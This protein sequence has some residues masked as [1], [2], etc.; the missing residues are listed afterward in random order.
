MIPEVLIARF[1]ATATPPHDAMSI[2]RLALFDWAVCAIA[3]RDEPIARILRDLAEAE[4]AVGDRLPPARAALING[5]TSHALDY[6]DTHFAHIGHTSVAVMPAVLAL[7][8]GRTL[9]EVLQA[10]LIGSEV[11]VRVGLWLGRDHYQIGFHQTAT[12]GAFGAAMAASRLLG[13]TQ[14][15]MIAALGLVST[16]AAGLKSQ[17]GTMGKPLNAGLA[18]E[19]GVLAAQWAAGGMTS[20]DA[21]LGGALGFGATHHGA[22]DMA[23]F[24]RMGDDWLM[25]DVSHK[26]HACCHGLHATLEALK[27]LNGEVAELT[28]TTHPRWM[29]VCNILT[30]RSGLECK[31]SYRMVTAMHLSGISTAAIDSYSDQ[32][33]TDPA[34]ADIR[35]RVHVH[36][37]AALTEMQAQIDVTYDD[38]RKA[39]LFHDLNAPLDPATRHDRLM[40]KARA[41][42]GGAM[43]ED[44]WGAV[45]ADDTRALARLIG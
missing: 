26:F 37:D 7:S 32:A 39:E 27:G 30:P 4:G 28:I 25:R 44:L 33:A 12:A 3:G 18:A 9:D 10:A 45:G 13:L 40:Q 34:L 14:P 11:A 36:E 31:F 43:A 23:G 5:A 20:A 8:Q 38:G 6:D 29:S 42:V 17:F 22:G 24:R 35:A 1:A 16:K 41:V 15:Q 2:I 19:T 21:G